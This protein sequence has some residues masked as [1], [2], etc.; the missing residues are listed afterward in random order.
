MDVIR[1][2]IQ[3]EN[4]QEI[5]PSLNKN[6][7]SYLYLSTIY[8]TA[9]WVEL[10]CRHSSGNALNRLTGTTPTIPNISKLAPSPPD[11]THNPPR[12]Y[13]EI[14]ML[15]NWRRHARVS[16]WWGGRQ[17]IGQLHPAQLGYRLSAVSWSLHK[18]KKECGGSVRPVRHHRWHGGSPHDGQTPQRLE[19]PRGKA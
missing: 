16:S 17:S 9:I 14:R 11:S 2:R 1:H 19:G 5:R 13:Q 8:D 4:V 6:R 10:Y 12:K 7:D 3:H 18:H 15:P